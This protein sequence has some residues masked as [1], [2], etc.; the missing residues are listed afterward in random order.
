MIRGIVTGPGGGSGATREGTL[1]RRNITVT[2][3]V[4]L[5]AGMLAAAP[6]AGASDPGGDEAR[7]D[8]SFEMRGQAPRQEAGRCQ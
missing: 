4:G 8:A 2:T 1:V 3:I 5:A 7:R 6:Q